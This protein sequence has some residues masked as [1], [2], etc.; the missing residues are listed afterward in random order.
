MIFNHKIT[1]VQFFDTN[2][3]IWMRKKYGLPTN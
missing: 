2:R 3:I 1:K